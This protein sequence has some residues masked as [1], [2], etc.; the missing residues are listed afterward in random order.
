VTRRAIAAV[1]NNYNTAHGKRSLLDGGSTGVA[2]L[3]AEVNVGGEE[4]DKASAES[5][6]VSATCIHDYEEYVYDPPPPTH[7]PT[8]PPPPPPPPPPTHFDCI[9]A[10][11]PSC[12][13]CQDTCGNWW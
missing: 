9:A 2:T 4:V 8:H 5:G 12:W 7:P 3:T 6:A 11:Y 10:P 13:C 1:K